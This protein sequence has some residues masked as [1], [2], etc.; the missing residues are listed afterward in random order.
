MTHFC[1]GWQLRQLSDR[2][3]ARSLREGDRRIARGWPCSA[4]HSLLGN[5]PRGVRTARSLGQS[6]APRAR[7]QRLYFA[8]SR[9][10]AIRSSGGEAG[11][12]LESSCASG[13]GP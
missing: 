10:G 13:E 1:L 5:H 7:D 9:T 12:G 4:L 8:G 6:G 11:I 3:A 2:R